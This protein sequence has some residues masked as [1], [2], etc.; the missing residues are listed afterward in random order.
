M[1]L[2]GQKLQCVFEET[3]HCPLLD[4]HTKVPVALGSNSTLEY[5]GQPDRSSLWFTSGHRIVVRC[6]IVRLSVDH[7]AIGW[8]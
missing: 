5:V 1:A 3:L 2:L 6:S 8:V 4:T 7:K